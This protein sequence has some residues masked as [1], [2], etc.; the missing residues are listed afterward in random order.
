MERKPIA[1]IKV[2][3]GLSEMDD[4]EIREYAVQLAER[5]LARVQP[6]EVD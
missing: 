2:P 6:K 5:V 3:K 4:D 1:F